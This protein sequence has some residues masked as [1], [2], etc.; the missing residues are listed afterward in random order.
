MLHPGRGDLGAHSLAGSGWRDR[1]CAQTHPLGTLHPGR[2]RVSA[3]IS[4]SPFE[5]QQ[6]VP[7]PTGFLEPWKGAVAGPLWVPGLNFLVPRAGRRCPVRLPC[8][9]L[10]GLLVGLACHEL[11]KAQDP[12]QSGGLALCICGLAD[13]AGSLEL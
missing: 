7:R 11:P 12:A 9:G 10:Q 4:L 3:L 5:K 2:G 13:G 1:L 8:P 6:P